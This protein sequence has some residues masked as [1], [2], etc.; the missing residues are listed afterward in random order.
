MKRLLVRDV[1]LPL[2]LLSGPLA[3]C[4]TTPRAFTSSDEEQAVTTMMKINGT[5]ACS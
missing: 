4:S 1:L 5:A 2:I 3:G